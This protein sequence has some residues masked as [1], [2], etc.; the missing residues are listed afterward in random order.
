MALDQR[1]MDPT[2]NQTY[3][4]VGQGSAGGQGTTNGNSSDTALY[5]GLEPHKR[6]DVTSG[7]DGVNP[8]LYMGID[9]LTRNN[10]E[11]QYMAL[12]QGAKDGRS[13]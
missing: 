7:G 12:N 1:S 6:N 10:A 2:Q 11:R 9:P 8:S 5:M 13:K 3:Q 4:A